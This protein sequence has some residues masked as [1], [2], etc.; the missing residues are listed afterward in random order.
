MQAHRI[1]AC[2]FHFPDREDH[3]RYIP[4]V[5]QIKCANNPIAFKACHRIRIIPMRASYQISCMANKLASILAISI[6]NSLGR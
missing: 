6:F 4:F 3:D 2:F 1:M 5:V